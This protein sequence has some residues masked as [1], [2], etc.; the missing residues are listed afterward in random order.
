MKS[1]SGIVLGSAS[2]DNVLRP[3]RAETANLRLSGLRAQAKTPRACGWAFLKSFGPEWTVVGGT[4]AIVSGVTQHFTY[5]NG[6]SSSLGVGQS[7]S[8]R[9]GSFSESGTDSQSSTTTEDYPT[10]GGNV[11]I[12]YKTQFVYGEYGYSCGSGYITYEARPTSFAGGA[13][14][15]K[16]S[17]RSAE[18]CVWQD[19]GT[20][21]TKNNTAALTFSFGLNI[22][23]IGLSLT[24]QTGF[25]SGA[26]VVYH[27]SVRHLLCGRNDFPGGNPGLIEAGD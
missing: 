8:G 2:S 15:S 24:S 1:G 14:Y 11:N 5:S 19:A 27:F 21:F 26:T 23:V 13:E 25:D 9:S 6:Q 20:T 4:Y 10:F 22:S 3:A 17:S 12:E 7:S 18:W 16:T